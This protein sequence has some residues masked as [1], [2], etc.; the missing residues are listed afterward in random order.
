MVQYPEIIVLEVIDVIAIGI[1]RQLGLYGRLSK[2]TRWHQWHAGSDACR[3]SSL[4]DAEHTSSHSVGCDSV[5][6]T[7]LYAEVAF[8]LGIIIEHQ[9]YLEVEA[10]LPHAVTALELKAQLQ[11]TVKGIAA[12]HVKLI[13][14]SLSARIAH[15]ERVQDR[16]HSE[17][18]LVLASKSGGDSIEH[19]V[20]QH[21]PEHIFYEVVLRLVA[22]RIILSSLDKILLID[23]FL[24]LVQLDGAHPCHLGGVRYMAQGIVQ[25]F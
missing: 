9:W 5:A 17:I 13:Y 10:M 8:V 2:S 12:S 1:A 18:S 22:Q 24:F 20:A 19:I 6:I 7:Y 4:S 21:I 15:I 16:T 3:I 11:V 25:G 23:G 14:Q